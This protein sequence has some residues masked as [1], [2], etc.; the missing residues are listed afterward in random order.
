MR[1]T[2]RDIG[3][4]HSRSQHGVKSDGLLD[5]IALRATDRILSFQSTPNLDTLHDTAAAYDI[6]C[7]GS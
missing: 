3:T 6:V 1:H 5:M 4:H 2:I 7:L